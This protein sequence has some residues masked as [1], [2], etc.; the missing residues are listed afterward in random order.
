M[1]PNVT[2]A[3]AL[4]VV[5]VWS[6]GAQPAFAQAD[7]LKSSMDTQRDIDRAEDQSQQ[8]VDKLAND[9]QSLL[10]DYRQTTRRTET[11]RVY[12]AHLEKVVASQLEEM[13]SMLRQVESL[14]TTNREVVP[15]M[16]RM[17][18]TLGEFI[19]SDLP[20]LSKE[21][22]ARVDSLRTTLDRADVATSEKYRRVMEAYQ[23]EN[24]YGRTIEAYP[25]TLT[26]GGADRSVD[27]LRIGRIGLFYQTPDRDQQGYWDAAKGAWTDLDGKYR[28]SVTEGL[29]IARKQAAPDLIVMPVRAP[30]APK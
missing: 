12:N 11:L 2:R 22:Q 24:E 28:A 3:L 18:D 29:R 15:L 5:C 8:R 26:L 19:A 7:P 21:R 16:V 14:E 23:I 27:F 10:A 30:E 17:I 13:D 20:F 1:S 6:I 9:T 4:A 25:G